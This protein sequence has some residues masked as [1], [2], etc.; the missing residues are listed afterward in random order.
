MTSILEY[1]TSRFGLPNREAE[2]TSSDDRKIAIYKWNPEQ[3]DEGV[4]IYASVG[5]HTWLGNSKKSCEFFIGITPEVDDIVDAVAETAIHG[6]GSM[7]VPSIGDTITLSFPLWGGT[8]ART[9]LFT[10][11]NEIIPPII[12]KKKDIIFIQLVPLFDGELQFKK[13]YS[14]EALWQAFEKK[15]IPYWSSERNEAI[16][17]MQLNRYKAL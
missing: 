14:E 6:N 4:T 8:E 16:L 13:T 7:N 3:T 5:A 12:I 11:G 17:N 1:Y 2:F 15:M 9:F 10:G